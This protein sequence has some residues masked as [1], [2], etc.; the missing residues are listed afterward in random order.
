[1][2]LDEI[3]VIIMVMMVVMMRIMVMMMTMMVIVVMMRIINKLRVQ[4]D[5]C[6]SREFTSAI[7]VHSE[8]ATLVA[9]SQLPQPTCSWK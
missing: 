8:Q 1:M 2:A 3:L 7:R 4:T 6:V 5:S 9:A